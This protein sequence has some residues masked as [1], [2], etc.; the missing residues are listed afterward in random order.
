MLDFRAIMCLVMVQINVA[1]AETIES[2][3]LWALSEGGA[4]AEAEADAAA[5]ADT[6]IEVCYTWEWLSNGHDGL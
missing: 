6:G 5:G 4:G 1:S 2:S 3:S